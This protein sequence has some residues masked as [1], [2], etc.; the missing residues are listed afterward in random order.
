MP[1][2]T[3]YKLAIDRIQTTP[4]LGLTA[5]PPARIDAIKARPARVAKGQQYHIQ[6]QSFLSEMKR[7]TDSNSV[8]ERMGATLL[9]C[10][11]IE[12]R[13]RAMY[14]DRHAIMHGLPRPS[15]ADEAR[16]FSEASDAGVIL[17]STSLDKD[18]VYR[19]LCQLRYYE[20]IDEY[21]FKELK[22]FT[23]VRNAMVHDAMYRLESF[24]A[25]IIH[26]QLPLVDHLTKMRQKVRNRTNKERD[27]HELHPHRSDYFAP[28]APGTR[29][30]RVALFTHVAGSPSSTINAPMSYGK[31]LYVIAMGVSGPPRVK[32]EKEELGTHELW[33]SFIDTHNTFPIFRKLN[34]AEPEVE[35]LGYGRLVTRGQAS[36]SVHHCDVVLG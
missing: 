31:P 26:A 20:D 32:F 7:I 21:T 28:M 16:E 36:A 33:N 35:Y 3:P 9:L 25:D 30:K 27:L 14:R 6:A 18:P 24:S 8:L 15:A 5:M 13:I 29:I 1:P 23:D 19:Q 2:R 17:R 10:S 34:V 12:G 11:F 4:T 22:L